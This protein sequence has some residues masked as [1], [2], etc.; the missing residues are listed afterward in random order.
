[1]PGRVVDLDQL[2]DAGKEIRRNAG[3]SL[4][5]LGDGVFCLE[6]HAKMNVIGQDTISMI[7]TACTEAETNGAALVVANQGE[8]F[9]AG[10]NVLLQT[11]LAKA[12]EV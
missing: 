12:D 6:F 3:A 7:M 11:L 1:M 5:D 2:R 9:S 8:N 10:A 4:L